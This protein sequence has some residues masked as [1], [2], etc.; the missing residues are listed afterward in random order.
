MR[1]TF[2]ESSDSSLSPPLS[3]TCTRSSRLGRTLP[4]QLQ[5]LQQSQREQP[6]ERPQLSTQ[7]S[8]SNSDSEVSASSNSDSEAME[9]NSDSPI[10]PASLPVTPPA[11]TPSPSRRESGVAAAVLQNKRTS[12]P[13]VSPKAAAPRTQAASQALRKLSSAGVAKPQQRMTIATTGQRIVPAANTQQRASFAPASRLSMSAAPKMLQPS[14]TAPS[15]VA[16]GASPPKQ[17]K[18]WSPTPGVD[19]ALPVLDGAACDPLAAGDEASAQQSHA[20]LSPTSPGFQ[21]DSTQSNSDAEEETAALRFEDLRLSDI[22]QQAFKEQLLA[23]FRQ[24]GMSEQA[25]SKLKV[26]LRE[27]SV[28]A[29]VTSDMATMT[30]LMD[31]IIDKHISVMGKP[32]VIDN[33]GTAMAALRKTVTS[34]QQSNADLQSQAESKNSELDALRQRVTEQQERIEEQ[35]QKHE[36]EEQ[37]WSHEQQRRHLEWEE[38]RRQWEAEKTLLD[39]ELRERGPMKREDERAA[40]QRTLLTQVN[41][42]RVLLQT[43]GQELVQCSEQLTVENSK[44]EQEVQRVT[45]DLHREY[46]ER[47]AMQSELLQ[48][49][50]EA[51]SGRRAMESRALVEGLRVDLAS[52]QD[53]AASPARSSSLGQRLRKWQA[54]RPA[55]EM[56]LT[57]GGAASFTKSGWP[58]A[59]QVAGISPSIVASSAS[60]TSPVHSTETTVSTKCPGS[61][62]TCL[63]TNA[64][65]VSASSWNSFDV[66]AL[67][68]GVRPDSPRTAFFPRRLDKLVTT[69]AGS[70]CHDAS[71]DEVWRNAMEKRQAVSYVR[72]K[73]AT[74]A[75]KV[76]AQKRKRKLQSTL[77]PT[78]SVAAPLLSGGNDTL[79]RGAAEVGGM[80]ARLRQNNSDLVQRITEFNRQVLTSDVDA[81]SSRFASPITLASPRVLEA[82]SASIGKENFSAVRHA[83]GPVQ[84]CTKNIDS[85]LRQVKAFN[86]AKNSMSGATT[87]LSAGAVEETCLRTQ[88]KAVRALE[89]YALRLEQGNHEWASLL[90]ERGCASHEWAALLTAAGSPR[91]VHASV[92][93]S[94]NS[95]DGASLELDSAALTAS[96]EC[97]VDR[98]GR[99]ARKLD[100]L[101][102]QTPTRR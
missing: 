29:E 79:L 56:M 64:A 4:P 47:E 77:S 25:I 78:T 101:S 70:R 86:E 53:T 89:R 87:D 51:Q 31:R 45:A 81:Y 9:D 11:S 57:P 98:L 1:S 102:Q 30:A 27:G 67:D 35:D 93:K 75:L 92:G 69:A 73:V 22:N 8:D 88:L 46:A 68:S 49:R 42:S 97:M 10:S 2:Y 54:E 37:Q 17:R 20:A 34:L 62:N 40:L 90:V 21:T 15:R 72:T 38:S 91:S 84:S 33:G 74:I 44:L 99:L 48:V 58:P 3:P 83:R 76:E 26:Q 18:S 82:S 36:E 6:E 5:K 43:Q 32:A 94:D 80:V 28:I 61:Q 41:R 14:K 23:Q 55:L 65:D 95:R 50:A 19:D 63:V 60:S 85:V 24:H 66:K 71:T 7:L 13:H 16:V 96:V 100:V 12:I 52:L 59:L 39:I